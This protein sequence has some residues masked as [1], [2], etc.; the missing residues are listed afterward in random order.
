MGQA[1]ARPILK[2]ATEPTHVLTHI[3]PTAR[4]YVVEERGF[5]DFRVV[6]TRTGNEG[7]HSWRCLQ[8]AKID[9]WRLRLRNL[10]NE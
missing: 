1:A 5:M 8:E 9:L 10:I 2:Y 4:P 3:F 6:D 7:L